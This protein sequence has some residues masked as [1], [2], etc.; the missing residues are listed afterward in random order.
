[1]ESGLIVEILGEHGE[2]RERHRL[3][4]QDFPACIG[5][6]YSNTIILSDESVCPEHVRLEHR[7]SGEYVALDLESVNGLLEGKTLEQFKEIEIKAE[8]LLKVG[9][10]DLRL[11]R[12]DLKV[13]PA[14]RARRGMSRIEAKL[15]KPPSAS[16]FIAVCFILSNLWVYFVSYHGRREFADLGAFFGA[17]IIASLIMLG[18]V[19]AFW[20]TIGLLSG[21]KGRYFYHLALASLFLCL[22]P[23]LS[24]AGDF[25][26]V[27]FNSRTINKLS[28]LVFLGI[29]IFL[30][31]DRSLSVGATLSR[32]F[33]WGLSL[34]LVT[35][36]FGAVTFASEIY[37]EHFPSHFT[38][39]SP[40]LPQNFQFTGAEEL[41]SFLDQIPAL[42]AR[43]SSSKSK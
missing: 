26:F 21:R 19:G 20:S 16:S 31:L 34:L 1:M 25:L 8:T 10:T 42:E 12:T 23:L 24:F 30:Y 28:L 35:L 15:A 5:R 13:P 2:V 40:V 3:G 27:G 4:E 9:E 32:N 41:E 11:V 14:R 43:L 37:K 36:G 33:R 17:S 7:D 29:P 22:S 39:S 18:G 38:N 6:G